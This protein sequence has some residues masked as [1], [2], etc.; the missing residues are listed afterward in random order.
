M[1]RILLVTA[2][3]LALAA[4]QARAQVSSTDR[5]AVDSGVSLWLSAWRSAKADPAKLQPLYGRNVVTYSTAT[6]DQVKKSWAEF[7]NVI[8]ELSADLA[9]A[10]ARQKDDPQVTVVQ[11]RVVTSFSS[12]VRLVWEK[13]NGVWKI[14]EQ[15]LPPTPIARTVAAD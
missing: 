15:S 1:K 6:A 7:A 12:G 8:P 11:D 14:V 13:T 5:L 9:A 10:I 3:L 4:S 2:S